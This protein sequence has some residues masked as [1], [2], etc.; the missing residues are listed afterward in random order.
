MEYRHLARKHCACG[1][2]FEDELEDEIARLF[3]SRDMRIA[4]LESAL[5]KIASG[6]APEEEIE[7]D[8]VAAWLRAVAEAALAKS[9]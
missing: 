6:D 5:C 3:V 4:E 7:C 8:T 2:P 9:T 1:K